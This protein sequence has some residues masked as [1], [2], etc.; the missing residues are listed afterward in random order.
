MNPEMNEEYSVLIKCNACKQI[1]NNKIKCPNCGNYF[2]TE[3]YP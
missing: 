2:I 3:I 1:T